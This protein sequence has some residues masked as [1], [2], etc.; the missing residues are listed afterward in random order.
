M[1]R[2]EYKK[3]ETLN[4]ID[5]AERYK[6][7]FNEHISYLLGKIHELKFFKMKKLPEE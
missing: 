6:F 1:K 4:L 7:Q 5:F 2:I 3:I